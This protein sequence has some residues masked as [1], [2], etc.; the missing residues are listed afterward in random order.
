M[1]PHRYVQRLRL[2]EDTFYCRQMARSK[3][4]FAN[5]ISTDIFSKPVNES[6]MATKRA[7]NEYRL[8]EHITELLLI[9]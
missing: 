6:E 2:A 9:E 3:F 8:L 5:L 4:D 7:T 1:I